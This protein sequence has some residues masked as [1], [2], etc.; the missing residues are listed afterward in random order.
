MRVVIEVCVCIVSINLDATLA[1]VSTYG[2][3]SNH[4]KSQVL[5]K[6]HVRWM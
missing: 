2:N 6:Y 1:V 3:I 4:T 5:L